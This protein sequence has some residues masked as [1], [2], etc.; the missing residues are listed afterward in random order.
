MKKFLMTV[1]AAVLVAVS[2][3]A[4]VYVGGSLGIAG[5][6]YNGN[7]TTSYKFVPEVGYNFNQN[8]AAGVAF[9]WAGETEGNAK[10][11]EVNPYVRYTFLH[12]KY[13][14]VFCDGSFGYTHQYDAGQDADLFSVGL[15]PGVAVNLTK[16][17]SF[18]THAGF[19]GWNQTKN[20]N[21]NA[22]VSHYGLDLDGNNLTFGLYLN[23]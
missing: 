9:G 10:S 21:N 19:L 6:D 13:V 14:N 4:Q 5:N 8:W 15:R 22:K 23:F 12:S 1:I 7:T 16:R 2:A 17:L 18:V 11:V 20:N 3:D